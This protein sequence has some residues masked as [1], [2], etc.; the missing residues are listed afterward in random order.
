MRLLGPMWLLMAAACG[1]G[2][3][4]GPALAPEA[5]A[6]APP[7]PSAI[8]GAERP[9]PTAAAAAT[10]GAA[11][12]T[13]ASAATATA[14]SDEECVRRGG[15]L[16]TESTYA[17]LSDRRRAP[18][19]P[20]PAPFRICRFPTS[21][22]GKA[23]TTSA[24]C[25]NSHCMCTGELDRP[26]PQRDPALAGLDGTPSAGVCRDGPFESGVWW[27]KVDAG[28]VNLHGLIVD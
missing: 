28:K 13:N 19:V 18:D 21:N 12:S 11:G 20:P 6:A 16:V 15:R 14:L 26:N 7:P 27:C 4:S 25:P 2:S 3:E 1:P 17:H 24:D 10:P 23:C 9:A 22:S 5:R 8:A